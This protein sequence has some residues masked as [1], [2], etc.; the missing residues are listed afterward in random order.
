MSDQEISLAQRIAA[1]SEEDRAS[2]L[3]GIPPSE[4]EYD[5]RFWGR[6]SQLLPEDDGWSTALFLGGRGSGKQLATSTPVPTPTG[7]STMGDLQTGDAVLDEVGRPCRVVIAHPIEI[8]D[9]AYRMTFDDGVHLDACS[10]HLWVTCT[11]LPQLI[12]WP[13]YEPCT[14]E[15]I[16]KDYSSS[17][18]TRHCI[19]FASELQLPSFQIKDMNL[20]RLGRH[21]VRMQQRIPIMYLRSSWKQRLI[22]LRGLMDTSSGTRHGADVKFHSASA[23]LVDDVIELVRTLSEAPRRISATTI[24]WIPTRFYPFTP[25]FFDEVLKSYGRGRAASKNYET[26]DRTRLITNIEPIDPSPMRCI[27]VSSPSGMYLVTEGFI[28]THNTRAGC[29]WVREKVRSMPK[30]RGFMVARTAADVRDVLVHGESGIMHTSPPSEQPEWESTKRLLTWPNGTTALAI[31]AEVPDL[32]RGPQGNWALCLT[33]DTLVAT[34]H[35]SG[36]SFISEIQPGDRVKTRSGW[37]LVRSVLLT[38]PAAEVNEVTTAYGRRV[39]ATDD[40]L[41]WTEQE[42]WVRCA[43]LKEGHGLITDS[44]PYTPQDFVID[45]N[46]LRGRHAV[47]DLSTDKREFFA[48][49]VLVHNCDELAAWSS[50]PDD[51]GLTAWQ[52]LR[53]ATRLG[54]N[55][56]IVAMTT[57]KRSSQALKDLL[58]E[59]EGNPRFI[60]RKSTT[61]ANKTNLSSIYLDQITA[62]FEGTGLAAQELGGEMLDD[63]E[64]A[65][66]AQDL[67][68]A[69][70]MGALPPTG[71]QTERWITVVGVDPSVSERPRDECGIVVATARADLPMHER[72]AYIL[73]DWS[74]QGPPRQWATRVVTTARKFGAVVIAEINQGGDLISSTISSIDPKVKMLTVHARQGKALRAEPVVSLYERGMVHHIGVLPELESQMTTWVPDPNSKSPDRVDALVYAVRALCVPDKNTKSLSGGTLRA[75]SPGTSTAATAAVARSA[76]GLTVNNIGRQ[77]Q[78]ATLQDIANLNKKILNHRTGSKSSRLRIYYRP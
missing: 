38:D 30:S 22:L 7:W 31:T 62:L 35:Q 71:L 40:H 32:L 4:L 46:R 49:G 34:S 5:W 41:F 6:S 51:S 33:A 59:A 13:Y 18:E 17:S 52:N 58:V 36:F 45:V 60:V 69:D 56:Q 9:K 37:S 64:G 43:D 76:A 53:L 75:Y 23:Q 74:V 39:R 26:F 68:D 12:S 78:P 28:P 2:L 66:W 47:W 14:T 3:D 16:A 20:W 11:S 61:Y 63:V 42:G 73:E 70:R 65:L 57:P 55:P 21:L 54:D 25:T 67:I 29:E 15:E 27:T 50:I 24:T 77:L 1:L 8:P 19:P 48:D 44:S 72:H 10:E